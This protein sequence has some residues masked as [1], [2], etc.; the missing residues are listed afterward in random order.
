VE[1]IVVTLV[2][3]D[4]VLEVERIQKRVGLQVPIVEVFSND[5]RLADLAAWKPGEDAA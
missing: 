5:A 2:L 3:W 1:G 4:Q